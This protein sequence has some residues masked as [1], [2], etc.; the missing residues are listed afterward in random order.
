MGPVEGPFGAI[1]SLFFNSE[2]LLD[3]ARVKLRSILLDWHVISRGLGLT[4]REVLDLVHIC[5]RAACCMLLEQA[6]P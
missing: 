5:L 6:N 2:G 1:Y 4:N 3:G